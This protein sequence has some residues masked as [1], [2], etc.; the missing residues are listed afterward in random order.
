MIKNWPANAKEMRHGFNPWV[1]K[2]PWSGAWQRT[3][4]FW[5]GEFHG[6]R[7]LVGYN[8]WG[9]E[10]WRYNWRNLAQACNLVQLSKHLLF[11]CF[12]IIT[13]IIE[14]Q[15]RHGHS[16]NWNILFSQKHIISKV[17]Y[18]IYPKHFL[19]TM[20]SVVRSISGVLYWVQLLYI[21]QQWSTCP[22]RQTG[23]QE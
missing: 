15:E 9:H 8:L 23:M 3:P 11:D 12:S 18:H 17:F 4:V 20:L 14:M 19:P 16:N 6:Q 21:L 2:I 7:C 13:P 10:E 22:G 1:R 5:P